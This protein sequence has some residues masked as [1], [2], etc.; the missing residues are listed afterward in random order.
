MTKKEIGTILSSVR[1]A[2]R[3]SHY[4]V[5]KNSGLRPSIV[6]TIEE[7]EKACTIDSLIKVCEVLD[8]ELAVGYKPINE[9]EGEDGN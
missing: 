8:M 7:G 3:L 4:M 6:R 1:R 5:G 2:K 9:G